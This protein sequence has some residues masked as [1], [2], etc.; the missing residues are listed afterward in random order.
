MLAVSKTSPL[1]Y[2]IAV[3]QSELLARLFGE[4]LVPP[5]VAAEL[6][7]PAAPHAVRRWITNPPAWL[8]VHMLKSAP[9]A[10][11]SAVLDPGEREAIQLARELSADFLIM[12]E[13][14]GREIVRQRGLPLVGALGIWGLSYQR[15]LLDDPL[16]ALD[17]IRQH[18]FRIS[19]ELAAR[20]RI[21]LTTRYAR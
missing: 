18:G 9:D 4:V 12:D 8:R 10:A 7:D 1:R 21:L 5:A 3:N 15:G 2:L 17:Q 16:Q 19:D 13:R 20:F 14:E 11:L 6:A